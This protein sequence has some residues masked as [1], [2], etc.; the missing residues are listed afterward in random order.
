MVSRTTRD[1]SRSV[2]IIFGPTVET[3]ADPRKKKKAAA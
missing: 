2:I 1:E 3:P